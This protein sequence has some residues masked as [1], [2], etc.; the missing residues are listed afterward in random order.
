QLS[1]EQALFLSIASLMNSGLSQDPLGLTGA[2]LIVLG[3]VTFLGR[4]ISLAMLAWLIGSGLPDRE[5]TS[6]SSIQSQ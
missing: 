1:G 5:I 2:P 3:I 4:M 6:C